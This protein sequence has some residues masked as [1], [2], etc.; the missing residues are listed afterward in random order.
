M[1]DLFVDTAY[2]AAGNERQR[3]AYRVLT[4][5]GLLE[6]L[7]SFNP[8]LVGTVPLGIDIPDSDL[9]IICQT[10]DIQAWV[11]EVS[12]ILKEMNQPFQVE[13]AEKNGGGQAATVCFIHDDFPIELYAENTP[14]RQQNGYRH[15]VEEYRILQVLGPSAAVL[16][17][18]WKREGLKTEPAFARMLGL[19]GDPYLALLDLCEWSYE[20]LL[21]WYHTHGHPC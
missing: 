16:I 14:S 2:L 11:T 7:A 9:D 20:Q 3:S 21:A 8:I 4:E 17:R 6:R 19:P 18:E 12:R 5:L 15:M 13:V 10:A 1:E